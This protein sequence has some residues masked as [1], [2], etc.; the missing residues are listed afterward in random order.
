MWRGPRPGIAP[1]VAGAALLCL[2]AAA[3]LS[4]WIAPWPYDQQML[5]EADRAPSLAHWFGTDEFGRDV[6]SR[7]LFG[8]RTSLSVALVS[9]SVSC[10]LGMAIGAICG[11]VG[12]PVDRWVMAAIDMT[13][14]FPEI[15][16][17]LLLVAI[18]GPGSTS[19][20]LAIAIAYLAQFTRLTRSQIRALKR[21]TFV[22]ASLC[23]G[24]GPAH[25]LLRRLLPNAVAPVVVV[26]MLTTG[27]AILLEATLGFF[28]MGAQPPTP[29][30]GGM[31]SSGSELLFE[32][33]WVILWP[34]AAIAAS[35]IAI[36]LFGDGVLVALDVKKRR[37]TH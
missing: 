12:G 30:W 33:P 17:A 2:V 28:G 29:S 35:V 36:N 20:V 31:M 8:A 3:F 22:E 27:D 32:A 10:S 14:C 5:A 24:A 9:I 25:I 34:G 23:F 16:L 4:P 6:L 1:I 11:Y 19:T 37:R 21:E 7:V 13:W 15:L 26:A 18:L